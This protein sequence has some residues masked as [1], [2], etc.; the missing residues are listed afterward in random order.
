MII[1]QP[2]VDFLTEHNPKS[3]RRVSQ[4]EALGILEAEHQRGHVHTAYFKDA[5]EGRFYAICNCCKCC[6]GGIEAMMKSGVP[7]IASSGFVA[8][9]DPD[10]MCGLRRL[11]SGLSVRRHPRQRRGGGGHQQMHGLRCLR[12]DLRSGDPH[13]GARCPKTVAIGFGC[14]GTSLGHPQ[15]RSDLRQR[16]FFGVVHQYRSPDRKPPPSLPASL[17]RT[18]ALMTHCL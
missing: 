5:M 9:I 7:M 17:V 10:L 16:L 11:R 4:S 8:Q 15:R 6:C 2:Y 13:P 12:C 3:A 18:A 1:G 14:F